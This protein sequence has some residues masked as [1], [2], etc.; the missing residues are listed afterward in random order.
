MSHD[1][2][3]HTNIRPLNV[4]TIIL[5]SPPVRVNSNVFPLEMPS[6]YHSFLRQRELPDRGRDYRTL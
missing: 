6:A 1:A 4:S 3:V 2:S 5:T